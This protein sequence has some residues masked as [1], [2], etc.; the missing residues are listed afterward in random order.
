MSPW[1]AGVLERQRAAGEQGA[2]RPR[3]VERQRREVD[4]PRRGGQHGTVAAVFAH[5]VAV[6]VAGQEPPQILLRA[7]A[8]EQ[9]GVMLEHAGKA[10]AQRDHADRVPVADVD[11]HGVGDARRERAVQRRRA[12][13]GDER[14]PAAG[15]LAGERRRGAQAREI[16][17]CVGGV[18][19]EAAERAGPRPRRPPR[20]RSGRR[21][22]SRAG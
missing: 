5:L 6:K 4:R 15:E 12:G 9:S 7:G 19:E 13:V 8:V 10:A 18:V 2:A 11:E 16:G 17:R 20:R 21:G 3:G 14:R 1:G 22:W